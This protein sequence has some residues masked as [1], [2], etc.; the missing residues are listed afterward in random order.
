VKQAPIEA[1]DGK[2][3]FRY[4]S[5]FIKYWQLMVIVFAIYNSVTIP[6][7][8]FYGEHG[9]S[10]ISSNQIAFVDAM[11]DFIFLIDI[12]ITFRTT[13][14][15]TDLGKEETDTHKIA[16][17][18]LRGSFAFDFASSVPFS[19]FVPASIENAVNILGLLKLLR[20][21]RLSVAVTSSNLPQGI[22]V[23]L[24]ILM[25]AFELLVV[26]HVLATIWFMLVVDAEKWVQNMDFMYN[27]EETAYQGYFEGDEAWWR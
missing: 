4:S 24:K 1:S 6:I 21:Q 8:I 15:D 12:I 20:I 26:M 16:I 17:R 9:P 5:E 13:Y 18:Y 19:V 14:L 10:V 22:K 7:A 27:G 2:I 3:I 11:V 25:M 23:Y